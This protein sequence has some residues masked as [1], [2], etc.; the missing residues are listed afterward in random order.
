MKIH[1]EGTI[2]ELEQ[3]F[4]WP[5]LCRLIKVDY[6]NMHLVPSDEV[7]VLTEDDFIRTGQINDPSV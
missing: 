1:I 2:S 7:F 4:D 6:Y 3:L 5:M